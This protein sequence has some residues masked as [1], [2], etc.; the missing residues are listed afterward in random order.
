MR[1]KALLVLA[2]CMTGIMFVCG[3]GEKKVI[4]NNGK[5]IV[6]NSGS[7]AQKTVEIPEGVYS[8]SVD[9]IS[10]NQ[11]SVTVSI[12]PENGES[13]IEVNEDVLEDFSLEVDADN[14]T[15][16]L[17]GDKGKSYE[18]LQCHVTLCA[19]VDS[20]EVCGAIKVV[21]EVPSNTESIRIRADGAC[22]VDAK[23]SCVNSEYEVGGVSVLDAAGI[24]A[25]HVTV[26][27]DGTAKASVY[28]SQSLDA[29]ASGV[30]SISYSGDPEDVT[31]EADGVAKIEKE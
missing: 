10:M 2:V 29:K 4:I 9:E 15:L 1:K 13:V 3:C 23:G 19:S 30:S 25:E 7:T 22:Q 21:Y 27:A 17:V 12:T 26:K 18:N 5:N 16:K 14:K 6:K 11:G 28:A 24:T 20:V 8:F 31:E